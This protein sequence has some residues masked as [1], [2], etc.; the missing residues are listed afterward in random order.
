MG[1]TVSFVE[2]PDD[3]ASW[4]AAVRPETK[5][6]Y[7][8][9]IS[10]PAGD[11][12]DIEVV[13]GVAHEHGVPLVVDNTIA[14]PYLVR[15]LEHGADIVVHS[16]T[17]YLGGHGTTI[18]GAIVDSG[19]FD[20][21][22]SGRFPGL[23]TADPSYHG[24]VFTDAVGPLAYLIKL[25]VQ[26]LRD[27][28]PAVAPFNAFLIAQG[29]ETLSLRME[30]HVENA[31]KVATF[32]AERDDVLSVNWASLPSSPWHAQARKYA[33]KGSGAV[34]AFEI[35]G[36]LAAGRAFV[37][38]L[39][40]HSHVANIGDVRSLVVHPG[41][42]DAQPADGGAAAGLRRHPGPGPPRRRGRERRRRPGRPAGRVRGGAGRPGRRGVRLTVRGRGHWGR[43]GGANARGRR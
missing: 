4:A 24:V 38:A 19:R 1:I 6:F 43:R 32:L 31:G 30:R 39:V 12:L 42:H 27:L 23:T 2:D 11:V 21:A 25:R 22:A 16:A 15:P 13:A 7:G 8:E 5:L 36:G 9:T 34:L 14:T 40:L 17:K 18:A 26:L 37:D 20:W 41:V 33:P 28:G 35:A 3:P 10:N 29:L